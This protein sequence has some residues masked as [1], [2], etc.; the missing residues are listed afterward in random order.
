ML[1]EDKFQYL[2][3]AIVLGS[4]AAELVI[5]IPPTGE[6]YSKTMTSL[7]N[8]FDHDELQVEVYVSFE[9]LFFKMP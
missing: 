1:N 2:I 5:S 6:N 8:C 9:N 4:R 7:K 3:K